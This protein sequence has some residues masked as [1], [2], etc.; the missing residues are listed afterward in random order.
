MFSRYIRDKTKNFII[1]NQFSKLNKL[2]NRLKKRQLN[3][4]DLFWYL[5]NEVKCCRATW[6]RV[7]QLFDQKCI[8]FPILIRRT[9]PIAS[10]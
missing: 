1:L 3:I 2:L 7:Y 8:L 5:D 10:R 9:S 6:E 4:S